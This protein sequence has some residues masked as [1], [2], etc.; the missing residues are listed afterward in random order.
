MIRHLRI[1]NRLIHGQVA[2]TWIHSGDYDQV[3]ACND[4]AAA[5]KLQTQ[6]LLMAVRGVEAKVLSMEKSIAFF[7][8]YPQMKAF[9]VVKDLKDAWELA[10]RTDC[11][12]INIGNQAKK[13]EDGKDITNNV[14]LTDTD[15]IYLKKLL[16]AGHEV[17]CQMLP[18]TSRISMKEAAAKW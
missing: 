5:D 1:D 17:S 10:S 18:N 3:V 4:Q 2:N 9:V 8:K 6:L 7:N 13:E 15:I 14:Y 11:M 16:E 12:A